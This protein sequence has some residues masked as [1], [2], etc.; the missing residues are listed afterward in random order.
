MRVNIYLT[1]KEK[2]ELCSIRDKYHLSFSTISNIIA[3]NTALT[4][5][6]IE[7]KEY[8]YKE[9]G[10]KTSIKPKCEPYLDE[11]VNKSKY[12]T[13][14]VKRY[15]RKEYECIDEKIKTKLLNKIINEFKE[16]YDPNWN[17]N[18]WNR[19]MPR[20]LKEHREYYRKILDEC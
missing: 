15:L 4:G 9:K 13:N 20:L 12:Y 2:K 18:E 17:G 6:I 3:R 10:Y 8:K 7:D 5:K 16:T 1:Y 14:A 11:I 19:R